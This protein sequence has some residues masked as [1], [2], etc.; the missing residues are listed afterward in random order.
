MF[1]VNDSVHFITSIVDLSI[2]VFNNTI[3][4][5]TQA[6]LERVLAI[7]IVIFHVM[8]H[9]VKRNSNAGKDIFVT[10]QSTG[11]PEQVFQ[12]NLLEDLAELA[13]KVTISVKT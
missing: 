13:V 5:I 12:I 2:V 6:A 10:I 4:V 11:V 3:Q 8:L 1:I 9:E 7:P